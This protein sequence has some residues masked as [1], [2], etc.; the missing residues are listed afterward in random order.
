MRQIFRDIDKKTGAGSVKLEAS[1]SED[2]W[3]IYNLVSAGDIL[4]APTIRKVQHESSTG[5]SS[6]ERV[7]ITLAISVLSAE[8][9]ASVVTI[10]IN[11][12]VAEENKHVRIGAFHTLDIEPHRAFVLTK[13]VW[14][15]MHIERLNLAIDPMTDADVGAVVMQDG[16]AHVLVITRSLTITR[17]RIEVNIPRKGK[18]AIY[19]RDSAMKSFFDAVLRATTEQLDWDQLKVIILASPGYVKDEFFKFALLEAARQDIRSFVENK[20]KIMLCHASSGQKNALD[21]VLSR[22]EVLSRLTNTKAVGEVQLLKEFNEMLKKDETRAVYGPSHVKFASDMGAIEKL[23]IT[24]S[25][26]RA[27]DVSVRSKYVNLVEN[28]KSCGTEVTVFS[29]Q[30]MSGKQLDAMSGVAAILRF[31]L[32]ELE[33]IDPGEELEA[34]SE[35]A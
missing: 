8:F 26:F 19:N 15:S 25:L 23:L 14:D 10:R 16:L 4:R 2:M 34:S 21:E 31:P 27:S 7:R 6:A 5:S 12:R 28:A 11:G 33:D 20:N 13:E 32:Q 9:D 35:H 17:A 1:D 22:P 24:D 18:N 29:T 30:H 3:H